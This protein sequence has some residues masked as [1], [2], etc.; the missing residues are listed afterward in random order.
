MQLRI[1]GQI[2]QF[3]NKNALSMSITDLLIHCDVQNRQVAVAVN[4]SF[5]PKNQHETTQL[6]TNDEVEIVSPMQGG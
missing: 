1:N 5:V 6:Q 3:E 4:G 2:E